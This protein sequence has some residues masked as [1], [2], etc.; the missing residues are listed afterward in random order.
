MEITV[1]S[2]IENVSSDLM[3]GEY[4][5]ER[6]MDKVK[7]AAVAVNERVIS[8]GKWQSCVLHENDEILII[9]ATQGG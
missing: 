5:K 2:K 1:N 3:L 7:G 9:L 8:R 6:G 4:L